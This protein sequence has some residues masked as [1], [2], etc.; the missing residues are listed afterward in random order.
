MQTAQILKERFGENS[1]LHFQSGVSSKDR[2]NDWWKIKQGEYPIVLGSRSAILA[3]IPN[4]GLIIIDEEHDAAYKE[5]RKPRFHVREVALKRAEQT[6]ATVIFGSA[7]PSLEVFQAARNGELEL[8]EL[9]ERVVPASAPHL[10]LI[11]MNHEKKKGALSSK[12]LSMLEERL[13]SKEQTILFLNRRGFH[14]YLFCHHCSWV[15]RCPQCSIVLVEHKGKGFGCHYCSY[16]MEKPLACP[17][18]K[19]IDLHAGGYGTQRVEQELKEKF[20][21][22]RVMRW[23]RDAVSEQGGQ[24]KIFQK[25]SSGDFDVLVGT[26]MVA[27]GF[28]FP[29]VT[30]VGILDVDGPLHFPDFRSAERCFQMV[31]Q[32]AGRAGRALV[33]GDV[34]IQTKMPDHYA[35]SFALKM[36]YNGFADKE[37]KFRQELGYPPYTHLVQIVV[38]SKKPEKRK[39]LVKKL[40]E[41]LEGFKEKMNLGIMGPT[42]VKGKKSSLKDS[43]RILLKVPPRDFLEF[44]DG[45]KI[46]ISPCIQQVSIDVDPQ[47]LK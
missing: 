5:D 2:L 23:D 47:F 45:L 21:W 27:H 26:Q 3:P 16:K 15:A 7:T 40:E 13:K 20:P 19:K 4:I 30:L 41:W 44:L 18:C 33:T 38:S 35:L 28:N 43:L 8:I 14:R 46:F 9:R 25:F 37:L 1:L 42:E 12:L 32:V 34:L 39:E 11:D 22:V 10:Q 31:T 17:E 29:K 6:N 24:E 36:D